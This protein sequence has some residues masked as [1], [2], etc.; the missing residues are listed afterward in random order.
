MTGEEHDLGVRPGGLD[1]RADA[2]VDFCVDIPDRGLEA[3]RRMGIVLGVI[4]IEKVPEL[5]P[6]AMASRCSIR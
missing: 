2:L 4:G 1:E 6:G 5:M 3:V